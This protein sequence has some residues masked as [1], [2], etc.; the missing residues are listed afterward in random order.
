MEALYMEDPT[1][2]ITWEIDQLPTFRG[3]PSL[4]R[5]ALRNLLNNAKKFTAIR[6]TPKIKI[7]FIEDYSRNRSVIFIQDNGIGFDMKYYDRLFG[8]FQV[9]RCSILFPKIQQG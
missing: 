9:A 8:V 2:K 3:D 6:E 4:L 1:G 5:I 7:G